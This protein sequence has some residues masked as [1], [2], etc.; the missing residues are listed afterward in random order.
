MKNATAKQIEQIKNIKPFLA[1]RYFHGNTKKVGYLTL[2]E[3]MDILTKK[4]CRERE[5][6]LNQWNGSDIFGPAHVVARM[7]KHSTH[8]EQS[9]HNKVMIEGN[10]GIYLASPVFL[11]KD[12]NKT[13]IFDKNEKTLR[14]MNI[15]N[16]LTNKA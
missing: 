15:F 14:L 16:S 3:Y 6:V 13:R 5:R 8:R 4:H 2:A 10:T 7:V 11:H 12:Y 9:T 1:P